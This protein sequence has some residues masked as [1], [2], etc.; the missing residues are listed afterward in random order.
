MKSFNVVKVAAEPAAV[1]GLAFLLA[2]TV[3]V[4]S[5]AA[6]RLNGQA[7]A[8][9]QAAIA[10]T[11]T[12]SGTVTAAKPFKAAHVY[13]YNLDKHVMY[14]VYTSAGAFRAVALFPGNYEITVRG[15]GLESPPQ[16]IVVKA[17]DN[18]AV[19]VAMSPTPDPN[20]YPSSVD[21]ALARSANGVLA[22]KPH[23]T[24][25]SYEEIYP[26]GPGRE[27]LETLCF[28]CHGE[29]YF[30]MRTRSAAGWR[31]GLEH[32]QG[33]NLLDKDKDRFGGGF[34]AGAATNFRFGVQDRTDV[35]E[36]LTKHFGVDKKPRAVRTDKE[37]PIDEAALARAQYI[38]YYVREQAAGRAAAQT[39]AAASDSEGASGG[40]AGV[41]IIMQVQIDA[42]GNRWAVDRGIPS[43]LVR[44][45]PR[46]GEIKAWP[47]PD[48]RAGVHELIIDR[49]GMVWV[50]EFSRTPEGKVDGGGSGS[51]LDSRLL[52]F[53]PKTE[54]W[55]HAIDLDPNDV[56]RSRQKGPL[57]A[58]TVDSKGRIFVNWMLSGAIGMFDPSTRKAETF[59][60]P[61]PHAEPY[62]QTIDP[63][64][65]VWVAEWNGGKLGRYN[66]ANESW[67]E[68]APPGYPANFRRGP[69]S[70]AEGNIWTGIWAAGKR[71]GKIAR[72][73]PRTGVWSLWDIPIRGSQPYEAS[74]DREGN[75]WF[76]DTSTPDR[77]MA[78]VRFNPRSQTFTYYPRPQ[79]V[80]DS[81][82]V[83]HAEDGSVH[84]SAR[85]GA[86]KDTSGFG[87]LYVDK[88]KIGLA[89]LMLNGAPG[90]PFKVASR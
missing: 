89:P 10:G 76:P 31:L 12:V 24:F 48:T 45:D 40:V 7:A 75:I 67:T 36:Y 84:Y 60:I 74:V 33:K 66:P 87:V 52:G 19:K 81:T 18:P 83:S 6:T 63:S 71:P 78:N 1:R 69:E 13:L 80:A 8:P 32:M 3:L 21:P 64:D 86:A 73:D 68:F 39:S 58:T 37:W 82:R 49:K 79:F 30:S 11:G 41:R 54:Q 38:E 72:L 46:T 55:E 27:V 56:I 47:L 42:Q 44:L 4:A 62:G 26:P 61:T 70:D 34:L 85:Y 16:K 28:N 35:L 17:G 14:M 2:A 9:G 88:D 23:V 53:N 15:R 22:P 29:N 65:N 20:Q 5:Y 90:Y 57:M 50:P 59:R 51:E 25:A 43:R 77:P